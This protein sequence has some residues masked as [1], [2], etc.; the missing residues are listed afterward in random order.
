V[1]HFECTHHD[2]HSVPIS[3]KLGSLWE[4]AGVIQNVPSFPVSQMFPYNVPKVTPILPKLVHC[5]HH[6]G[7]IQNVPLRF[8]SGAPFWLILGFTDREHRDRTTGDTAKNS[9]NEPLGNIT[10]TFFGKI[11]DVSISFPMETSRSHD[12]EHCE[13]T[14]RNSLNEPLRNTAVTFFGKI[15]DVPINYLMGTSQSHDLGHCECTDHSPGQGNC[16]KTGRENS[17]CTCNVPG[18]Y[19]FGTLSISL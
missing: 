8:I 14:A 3:V 4:N 5:G 12:L 13:C 7:Y 2:D 10:G 9:L 15:Q 19:M 18:G 11:Q 17:E 1:A 16:R 6:D